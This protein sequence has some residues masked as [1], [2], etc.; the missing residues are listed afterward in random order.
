MGRHGTR[1]RDN[2]RVTESEQAYDRLHAVP[3]EEFVA[4]RKRLAKELRGAGE[5]EAAAELSRFPKPTPPAWA[6]N[7]LAREEPDTVAGW[8][9]AAAGLRDAT[10]NAGRSSGDAVRAAIAAHRDATR[11]LLAAARDRTRPN[12]R[13]LSEP[14]LDRVRDLL[15]A[16][17]ADP[18][19]AERLRAG[20]I[21]EGGADEG[22]GDE[23]ELLWGAEMAGAAAKPRRAAKQ[24]A[25]AKGGDAAAERR[26]TKEREAREREEAER[27][28]LERLVADAEERLA[29]LRDAAEERASA[30]AEADERLVEARR[31]LHRTESEAAAAREA[32]DEAAEHV[33]QVERELRALTAKLSS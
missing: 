15:G 27:A 33:E 14:M 9:D 18:E 1:P 24:D 28:E 26:A 5:R 12:G 11:A 3:L 31:T 22:G 29:E 7:Q 21:V 25:P 30:A 20:R 19:L 23:G 10:E 4:E 8:L 32:A 17:T 16:A 6:L 13:E 2:A